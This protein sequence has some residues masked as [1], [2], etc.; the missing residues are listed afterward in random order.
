VWL[1]VEEEALS[2]VELE[3]LDLLRNAWSNAVAAA[4]LREEEARTGERLA[5]ANRALAE[6]QNRLAE[7]QARASLG[8]LA[9]G[10]AHEMNNP[11]TVI[12][13][14][15]QV[16]LTRLRDAQ[17]KG[18]TEEIVRQAQRL[19]DL[20]TA[21]H[22]YAEPQEPR[23]RECNPAELVER[24]AREVRERTATLTPIKLVVQEALP[25]AFLD[26]GQVEQ[27]LR[28]L[29]LNAVEAQPCTQIEVRVQID[30]FDDRLIFQVIDDGPG[31]SEH[32][33]AHAFD[34]FFS[35]KP[36]GRQPGLGLARARRLVEANNGRIT[37]KNGDSA[38]GGSGAVA[39]VRI[40]GWR[41][42]QRESA[43]TRR[44]A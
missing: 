13:G 15:A 25:R 32:A 40:D 27:A 44:V 26:G 8:E 5:E 21:L 1:I 16:L 19:S 28:E 30:P 38:S 29:I 18:M 36:A 41:G 14:T 6:A 35:E 9:A 12:S 24:A 31:L 20:I 22:L 43:R 23:P 11:L 39:T 33:L 37:L 4:V 42:N 34:P 3:A 10:A 2:S 7:S 17:H